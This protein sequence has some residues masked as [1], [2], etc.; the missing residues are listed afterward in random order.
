[1]R[2]PV[3]VRAAVELGVD[4]VARLEQAVVG[5]AWVSDPAAPG[6]EGGIMTLLPEIRGQ[7]LDAAFGVAEPNAAARRPRSGRLAIAG[8]IM[9]TA[10]VA[11]A[12]LLSLHGP[13]APPSGATA[14]PTV[15]PP[16]VSW[17]NALGRAGSSTR[18]HDP[19]CRLPLQT[20]TKN[21]RFPHHGAAPE[22]HLDPPVARIDGAGRAARHRHAAPG[23]SDRGQRDLRPLRL[24]GTHRRG[25]L[26]R[27]TGGRRRDHHNAP[28]ALLSG[29]SRRLPQAA[30][31]FPAGQRAAA[32]AYAQQQF[33]HEAGAGV[34][35]ITSGQGSS[36]GSFIQVR[37]LAELNA[38]P[39]IA[40]G[41]GGTNTSTTTT[42]LVTREVASVTATY[43]AQSYPGRVSRTFSVTRRPV[44]NLV[45]FHLSGAWDPPQ[46]TFRSSTGTVIYRSHHR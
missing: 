23:V 40:S 10:V 13:A 39:A 5:D 21:Q 1:M 22:H 28:G 46:L 33:N 20:R 27:R 14:E 43:P 2:G 6:G 38:D 8:S 4:S 34:A 29:G 3:G 25:P 31:R 35:V 12:F 37:R 7:V 32:I 17:V 9:L 41:G 16:P 15:G 42:L 30:Q 45:I 36:G 11:A 18:Q 44:R 19:A 26:L 24:A